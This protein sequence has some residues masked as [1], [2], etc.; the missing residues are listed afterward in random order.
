MRS[1]ARVT[2]GAKPFDVGLTFRVLILQH[3]YTLSDDAIDYQIRD[4]LSF[5][6]FL[7]VHLED[8]TRRQDDLDVP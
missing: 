3:F 4:R 2:P 5:M 1:P 6:R 7:G 8:R